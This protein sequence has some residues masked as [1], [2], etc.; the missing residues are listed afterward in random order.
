MKWIGNLIIKKEIMNFIVHIQNVVYVH[1]QKENT[2][3][4]EGMP[5]VI[6]ML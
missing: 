6:F 3:L 4:L 1:W 2:R 5:V